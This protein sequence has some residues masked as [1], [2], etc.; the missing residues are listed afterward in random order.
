VSSL[1]DSIHFLPNGFSR[2]EEHRIS[3]RFDYTYADIDPDADLGPLNPKNFT[4]IKY[5][6]PEMAIGTVVVADAT[7]RDWPLLWT[8]AGARYGNDIIERDSVDLS[9]LGYVRVCRNR[10]GTDGLFALGNVGA[11]EREFIVLEDVCALPPK[12]TVSFLVRSE[13]GEAYCEYFGNWN[14]EILSSWYKYGVPYGCMYSR[15]EK[16]KEEI[17][18]LSGWMPR[19]YPILREEIVDF[20]KTRHS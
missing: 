8:D 18:V 19:Y 16:A 5:R 7:N 12:D 15:H 6:V 4:V 10:K 9:T 1:R 3:F 20:V 14:G 2:P 13:T 11:L 17:Y